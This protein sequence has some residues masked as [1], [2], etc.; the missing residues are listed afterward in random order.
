MRLPIRVALCG[1]VFSL[2]TGAIAE[3]PAEIFDEMDSRKRASFGDVE[4]LSV[5]KTTLSMCTLEYFEKESTESLDGRGTVNYMRLVPISEVAERKSP[6]NPVAKAT[7]EELDQAAAEVRLQAPRVDR[8]FRDEMATAGL[9]GGLSFLLT[10]PPSDKPWLSPMPGDMM[11]NMATMLEAG[12]EGKKRNIKQEQAAEQ[13]AQRDPLAAAAD[14]TRIVGHETFNNR[15]AIH[16][17]AEDLNYSQPADD[18]QFVLNTLHLWVDAE[19]YVPLK[20]QMEGV[21][22][23]GREM[24]IEREDMGYQTVPGCGAMY[25]P[26]RSVMRMSGVLT[27]AEQAQMVEAKEKLEEFET[28]MAS[29]PDSQREMI[30]RQ[31]GPQMEMFRNMASGQ[32]IEVVSL[33][34]GM[35]C[36]AGPPSDE[37]YMQTVP[38]VSQAACIG[39]VGD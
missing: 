5:M 10:N 14:A 36:N 17:V 7:P 8:A 39:F 34:V 38:G 22:S 4:N 21:A 29:L 23:D 3:T 11:E 18:P 33:T 37:E 9:P 26:H 2:S 19:H 35:R 13:E 27:P 24:R 32:G 25:E 12:A 28:Q 31:M 6:N 20:M 1:I 15:P 16:L 30:M